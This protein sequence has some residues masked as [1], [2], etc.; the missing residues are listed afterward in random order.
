MLWK[1]YVFKDE[2]HLGSFENPAFNLD[3]DQVVDIFLDDMET[4]GLSISRP[5]DPFEAPQWRNLLQTTYGSPFGGAK[6]PFY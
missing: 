1:A 2:T 5:S 4:R 6:S 3:A